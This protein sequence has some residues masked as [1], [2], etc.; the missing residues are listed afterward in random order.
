MHSI[1]R[2]FSIWAPGKHLV[3][4]VVKDLK[5]VEKRVISGA[6]RIQRQLDMLLWHGLPT[7]GVRTTHVLIKT[8][9]KMNWGGTVLLLGGILSH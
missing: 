2:K 7:V 1:C 4:P 3:P 6:H 8:T 9:P 5:V